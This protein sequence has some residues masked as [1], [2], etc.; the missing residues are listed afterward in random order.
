MANTTINLTA[1]KCNYA[2]IDQP[3]TVIKANTSN[4]YPLDSNGKFMYF[5]FQSF[6]DNLKYKALINFSITIQGCMTASGSGTSTSAAYPK[7]CKDF[8]ADTDLSGFDVIV[9]CILGTG[10]KGEVRG[11]AGDA[12]NTVRGVL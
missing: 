6:P 8:D 4:A 10:F 3:L 12:I 11:K 1:V 2:D 9:D 5:G 7:V